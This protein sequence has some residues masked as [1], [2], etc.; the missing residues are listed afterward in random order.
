MAEIVEVKN[1]EKAV[2]KAK[3]FL[4]RIGGK[5]KFLIKTFDL[6]KDAECFANQAE[7]LRDLIRKTPETKQLFT[8]IKK[9]L[10]TAK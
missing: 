3:V 8:Q 4:G 6:K 9:V 5:K 2:F 7:T 1:K 10:E